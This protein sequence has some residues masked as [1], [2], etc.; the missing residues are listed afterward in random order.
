M[1]KRNTALVFRINASTDSQRKG[2]ADRKRLGS[3]KLTDSPRNKPVIAVAIKRDRWFPAVNMTTIRYPASA[4]ILNV[5]A[6]EK[7]AFAGLIIK[8]NA[9]TPNPAARTISWGV[10]ANQI[11]ERA[12]KKITKSA[13]A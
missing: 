10:M 2:P 8:Y 11:A 5:G 12:T 9:K 6:M 13:A 7:L 1:A 4:Q 3:L